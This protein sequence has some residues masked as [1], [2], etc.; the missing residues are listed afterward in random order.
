MTDPTASSSKSAAQGPKI[1]RFSAGSKL[2]V[3]PYSRHVPS[4]DE[5]VEV[6]LRDESPGACSFHMPKMPAASY[7]VVAQ[8]AHLAETFTLA[9]VTSIR[10]GDQQ[11][12]YVIG[13]HFAE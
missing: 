9:R 7:L 1:R 5:F 11:G 8:D 10:F 3:A 13:C 2:L 6:D 4:A 12:H